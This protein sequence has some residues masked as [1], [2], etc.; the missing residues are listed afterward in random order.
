MNS[1]QLMEKIRELMQSVVKLCIK[2]DEVT[3]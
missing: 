2:I 3:F 1:V